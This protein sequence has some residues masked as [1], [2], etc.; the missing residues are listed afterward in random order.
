MGRAWSSIAFREDFLMSSPT[1]PTPPMTLTPSCCMSDDSIA[2]AQILVNNGG[3]S[4]VASVLDLTGLPA[5]LA[6]SADETPKLLYVT[7]TQ[8]NQGG[9]T[10]T[11]IGS[12]TPIEVIAGIQ[13]QVVHAFYNDTANFYHI[14]QNSDGTWSDPD[15]FPLMTDIGIAITPLSSSLIAYGV[16]SGGDLQMVRLDA[17]TNNWV[18]TTVSFN[19]ALLG[20]DA[21]LVMTDETFWQLAFPAGSSGVNVYQGN[22]SSISAGPTLVSTAN[23][24]TAILLGFAHNNSTQLLF[25]DSEGNLYA[26]ANTTSASQIANVAA[27]G[28]TAFLDTSGN[29]AAYLPD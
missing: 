16:T 4:P 25:S 20:Q 17:T 15:T 7:Q 3:P 6:V 21:L 8:G 23:Q 13:Q 11:P 14:S 2:T 10:A 12:A 5:C 9:W 1:Y 27:A 29:I 18:A 24:V 28:G 22:G 26:T 19:S